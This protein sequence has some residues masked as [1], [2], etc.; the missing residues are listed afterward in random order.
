MVRFVRVTVLVQRFLGGFDVEAAGV[1]SCVMLGDGT[2]AVAEELGEIWS[3]SE[4]GEPFGVE[5]ALRVRIGEISP[6]SPSRWE[7][8]GCRGEWEADVG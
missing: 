1:G 6:V 8:P 4:E 3:V 2:M 5:E 7:E